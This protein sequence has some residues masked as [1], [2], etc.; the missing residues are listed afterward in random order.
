MTK[1]EFKELVNCFKAY[2]ATSSFLLASIHPN[3]I[4]QLLNTLGV[5]PGSTVSWGRIDNTYH[6]MDLYQSLSGTVN[7][8]GFN[9]DHL[10][11][12]L[13]PIITIL[14][15]TAKK[16]GFLNHSPEFEFFR[17]I[18]NAIS[19]GN[20]FT[21]SQHEPSRPASFKGKVIDHSLQGTECVLFTFIGIGDILDLLDHIRDN[22]WGIDSGTTKRSTRPPPVCFY[23]GFPEF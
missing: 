3:L 10:G 8:P 13:F 23:L 22:I 16:H 6:E 7:N 21:F 19:H 2:Y 15:D 5:D 18:R 20:R 9:L 4:Q 17:H 1:D 12:P 11:L 14:H